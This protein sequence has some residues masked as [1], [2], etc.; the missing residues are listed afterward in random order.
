MK[1]V[2]TAAKLSKQDV[3]CTA[4]LNLKRNLMSVEVAFLLGFSVC[5][6]VVLAFVLFW[7]FTE[8][9]DYRESTELERLKA[10][11]ETLDEVIALIDGME[12]LFNVCGEHM[13]KEY[14][15]LALLIRE[16]KKAK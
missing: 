5:L 11:N 14:T 13:K 7:K 6:N 1:N 16:L 9:P 4:G 10:I 12:K 15:S 2:R 8:P 3:V